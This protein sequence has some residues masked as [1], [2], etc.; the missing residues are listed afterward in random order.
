MKKPLLELLFDKVAGL[1]PYD[2]IKK[3]LQHR[4]FSENIA[5]FIRKYFSIEHLRTAASELSRVDK[6]A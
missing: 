1:R 6:E 4:Y 2:F 5:K 3:R